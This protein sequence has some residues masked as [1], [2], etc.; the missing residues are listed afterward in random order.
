MMIIILIM[1]QALYDL[2]LGD[3][4]PPRPKSPPIIDEDGFEVRENDNIFTDLFF[5]PIHIFI[6]TIFLLKLYYH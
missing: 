6:D 3:K 4:P 2:S 1:N 5:Y